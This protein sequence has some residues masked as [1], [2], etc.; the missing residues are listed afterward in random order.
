[1]SHGLFSDSKYLSF[2]SLFIIKWSGRGFLISFPEMFCYEFYW[3]IFWEVLTSLMLSSVYEIGC[4]K[5]ARD[6]DA[7]FPLPFSAGVVVIWSA[8]C[9]DFFFVPCFLER[10]SKLTKISWT[11]TSQS[12]G[13]ADANALPTATV[14]NNELEIYWWLEEVRLR[15]SDQPLISNSQP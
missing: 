9:Q 5:T 1:M 11:W 7:S 8:E 3:G 12:M 14:A 4:G 6:W 13:W 10:C 15:G 2:F